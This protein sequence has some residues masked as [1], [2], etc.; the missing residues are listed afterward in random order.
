LNLAPQFARGIDLIN[1]H[2]RR[3][4]GL[5]LAKP[6]TSVGN[7]QSDV[8]YS[9]HETPYAIGGALGIGRDTT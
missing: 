6:M 7:E 4:H 2:H 3:Q 1:R 5:V 8:E 9:G